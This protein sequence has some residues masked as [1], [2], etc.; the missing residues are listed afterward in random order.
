M[1]RTF[2]ILI[3]GI[4]MTGCATSKPVAQETTLQT[5]QYAEATTTAFA[6]DPAIS[7][8][9]APLAIVS[10]DNR[11]TSAFLGF[12]PPTAEFFDVQT[13]DNQ[14]YYNYPSYYQR[15]VISDKIGVVY[16]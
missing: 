13:D 1:R 15:D 11:G 9:T 7:G 4:L 5:P 2:I 6:F 14:E 16:H 12:E 3:G 8:G 10:R